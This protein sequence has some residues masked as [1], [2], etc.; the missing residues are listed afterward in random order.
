MAEIG[1]KTLLYLNEHN[2]SV[3]FA[4][5]ASG[6][7]LI[8]AGTTALPQ[9]KTLAD[10]GISATGHKHALAD[11]TGTLAVGKGGTGAT[12]L[13]GVLLGNGTNAVTALTSTTTGHV[14][15]KT[16]SGYGF[17]ALPSHASTATTYGAASASNYGHAMATGTTPKAPAS[18]AALGT[19]TAKFAR[20]DHVHPLQTSVSGNAGTATKLANSRN[21]SI[22][23]GATANPVSFDGSG[24]VELTVTSLDASKLDVAYL[25]LAGGL[26]NGP[27]SSRII[28]SYGR[29]YG[30]LQ[31]QWNTSVTTIA[32]TT[33]FPSSNTN[34]G[35]VPASGDGEQFFQLHITGIDNT[36]NGKT[37][38]IKVGIAVK[39]GGSINAD[40]SGWSSIGI[41]TPSKVQHG[42]INYKHAVIITLPTV[43]NGNHMRI[44]VDACFDYWAKRDNGWMDSIP[45]YT[46][47]GTWGIDN[48]TTGIT[49]D[50]GDGLNYYAVSGNH[51]HLY[52]GSTEPGGAPNSE[53][54]TSGEYYVLGVASANT[55]LKFTSTANK[56]VKFNGA[57]GA[58]TA[59]TFV[60][61]LTGN[62]TGNCTGSSGSCTGNAATAS[63]WKTGRTISL[64]GGVTGTS[65][66]WTGSGNLSIATTLSSHN[67]A[68][69]NINSGVFG[70]GRGG[71]G[72]STYAK[73]DIL[74]CSEDT[75]TDPVLSKLSIGSANQMLTVDPTNGVPAW[76]TVP[77][78]FAVCETAAATTAKVAT[79]IGTRKLTSDTLTAGTVVFVR[80]T[81]TNSGAVGSLTLNIDGTGAKPIKQQLN[82][83]ATS[84]LSNKAQLIAGNTY[85]FQYNGTNWVSTFNYNNTYSEIT[86]DNLQ[87]STSSTA[88]LITGRRFVSALN[89]LIADTL[90][91]QIT[92]SVSTAVNGTPVLAITGSETHWANLNV[93]ERRYL[94]LNDSSSGITTSGAGYT[95]SQTANSDLTVHMTIGN[96]A[97]SN[98][99]RYIT[100]PS[101]S[102]L[103]E[104][105]RIEF[106]ITNLSSR[107]G[108]IWFDQG[109]S[110]AS[111]YRSSQ[112]Y[113]YTQ[114]ER[115][116]STGEHVIADVI[117][118]GT[119]TTK[120]WRIVKHSELY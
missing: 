108:T 74:Y 113:N 26:M 90:R 101:P 32:I 100:L 24:D 97:T 77:V 34:G 59:P 110:D 72:L 21:F 1:I 48:N 30:C 7:V 65:A 28:E 15:Q 13:T 119:G 118:V 94:K 67:H 82:I 105:D 42:T 112:N 63:A 8:G 64:T 84:D 80:F 19:E 56:L 117:T 11:C 9:W 3:R 95:I 78:Y 98:F 57:T 35:T 44:N 43:T 69:G 104:G 20:G 33:P 68:A 114:S 18:T 81:N 29:Y 86:D 115:F 47:V 36:S 96:G 49:L 53:S 88:G 39:V 109:V 120:V 87:S 107:V 93:R 99:S 54:V 41:I 58:L 4:G 10:A 83:S 91:L 103:T 16:S 85:M 111:L 22:T 6:T 116:F 46:A 66:A 70:V 51:E 25:P 27:I 102:S 12:S 37:L 38:D 40:H 23:G 14:L 73:G 5:G 92:D 106:V 52:A 71:T 79:S 2:E 17:A 45:L 76:D 61:A 75:G 55:A 89:A 50:S 60:G 62:V 31:Y